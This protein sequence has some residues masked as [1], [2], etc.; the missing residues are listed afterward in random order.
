MVGSRTKA[1]GKGLLLSS[2]APAA[3]LRHAVAT[4]ICPELRLLVVV[5]RWKAAHLL[6]LLLLLLLL[7]VAAA[8]RLVGE[9]LGHEPTIPTAAAATISTATIVCS[10]GIVGEATLVS[11][12]ASS[13]RE[14]LAHGARRCAG[15]VAGRPASKARAPA[16]ALLSLLLLVLALVAR[17]AA[18]RAATEPSAAARIV[19]QCA[20][21]KRGPRLA[22]CASAKT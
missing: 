5:L 15:R 3:P 22:A 2:G 19:V 14:E 16:R 17:A 12:L 10:W 9:P 8:L 1:A 7:W 21:T 6:L 11:K 4:S 20:S 13:L 18:P